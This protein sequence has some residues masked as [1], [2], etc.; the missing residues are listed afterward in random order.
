MIFFAVKSLLTRGVKM[1]SRY[2]AVLK[3]G[4][5]SQCYPGSGDGWNL[6]QLM[7]SAVMSCRH[8]ISPCLSLPRILYESSFISVIL[9]LRSICN[10]KTMANSATV[11]PEDAALG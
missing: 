7:G 6:V 4:L 2:L 10:H 9:D 3:N 8:W 11:T 1:R 5:K